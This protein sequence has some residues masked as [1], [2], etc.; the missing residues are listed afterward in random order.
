MAMQAN[1]VSKHSV[2]VQK[3]SA[4]MPVIK[5]YNMDFVKDS[6]FNQACQEK[7]VRAMINMQALTPYYAT[8]LQAIKRKPAPG[9]GTFAVTEDCM[10]YDMEFVAGLEVPELT[11][12]LIHEVL[13]IAMQCAPRCGNRDHEL[14]NI[15]ND[16][17]VNTVICKDFGCEYGAPAVTVDKIGK[18]A[19]IK[20]PAFGVYMETIGEHIDLSTDTPETI[21]AR[22]KQENDSK[23][24][25][26]VGQENG[27]GFAQM[28]GQENDLEPARTTDSDGKFPEDAQG[29]SAPNGMMEVNV[30]FCGKQLQG[31]IMKDIM[32]NRDQ[33]TSE[34]VRASLEES[35]YALQLVKTKIQMEE[36]ARGYPLEK[37][38]GSAANLTQR[39]VEFGLSEGVNWKVLLRNM[40]NVRPKKMF[41][42]AQPYRDYMNLGI[43]LADRRTIGKPSRISHVKFAIDVSGSVSEREL[44]VIL[45]EVGNIFSHFKMEGELIYWSTAVRNAGYF[46]SLKD[47]LKIEPISDGGTDVRCVFEYLSGQTKVN[48][49]YEQD[50]VRDIQ[51]VFILTDGWFSHNYEDFAAAFG[52]KV[53][54]LITGSKGNPIAFAPPF[55]RVIDV[56]INL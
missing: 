50:K 39:Y 42:L 56:D 47:L 48:M 21:Y 35:K 5:P 45:S 6:E 46:S 1:D 44:K 32:S 25:Q 17:Y 36:E 2:V 51:G 15:A 52:R 7:L 13:H 34:D 10:Y 38:A 26:M 19:T 9:I 20:A 18:P 30:T 31:S 16:L 33:R 54:W 4:D 43:T 37:N 8:V 41:T 12:V 14:W 3:T 11:Y 29:S 27:G 28:P 40:C 22:L 24:A 53:V 55:G 49:K 23:S